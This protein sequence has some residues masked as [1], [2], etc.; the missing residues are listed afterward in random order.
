MSGKKSGKK[1]SPQ[2]PKKKKRRVKSKTDNGNSVFQYG[3][4]SSSQG[5]NM[6]SNMGTQNTNMVGMSGVPGQLPGQFMSMQA[7]AA[8]NSIQGQAPTPMMFST[9]SPPP[10]PPPPFGSQM[11][12]NTNV[13]GPRPDWANEI[14]QNMA[15]MKKEL[16]KL[17]GM[18]KTLNSINRKVESLETKVIQVE[19]TANNCVKS[20]EFLN[21]VYEEQK[22]EL[23]DAKKS[24][25]SLR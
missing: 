24:V 23:K 19:Q 5:S 14:L 8:A 3:G 25:N 7:P 10:Q 12:M 15:E 17:G 11:N 6:T 18:E 1:P 9:F 2:L 13:T 20:C 21:T 16:S 4:L 22:K